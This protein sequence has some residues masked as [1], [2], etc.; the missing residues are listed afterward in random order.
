MPTVPGFR[1]P[2]RSVLSRRD[3]GTA[4][5]V[6]TILGLIEEVTVS[7]AGWAQRT[8]RSGMRRRSRSRPWGWTGRQPVCHLVR[9][10]APR[11]AVRLRRNIHVAW[12][13]GRSVAVP[14][15]TQAG[16]TPADGIPSDFLCVV[17]AEWPHL[18]AGSLFGRGPASDRG[19]RKGP[20][21]RFGC[22][23]DS[24]YRRAGT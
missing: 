1:K 21:A 4:L 2:D 14:L 5:L 7:H 13:F 19:D 15:A 6:F 12:W 23:V 16:P 17:A 24:G 18:L 20:C 22:S 10:R 8:N 9:R 11:P 3:Q